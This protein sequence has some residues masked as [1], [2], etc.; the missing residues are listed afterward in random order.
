MR[1]NFESARSFANRLD[2]QSQLDRWFS[3]RANP[4]FHRGIRARP[5]ERLLEERSKMRPLPERTPPSAI[6]RVIRVSQQPY[7]RFDTND[8]SLDPRFAGR[9]VEVRVGQ[10]DLVAVAL[11]SGEI[12]ARHYRSFAKHIT[13]TD[14]AHQAQLDRLR[15]T[16]CRGPDV[17]VET[18]PLAR[19]D[20]LIPA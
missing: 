19:Y 15:G 20:A 17:E 18:R 10:H 8:Y 4:R 13:F 14:P 7:L 3:E 12:V 9:R 2:Y 16:R 1:S 11:D 5:S 6:R